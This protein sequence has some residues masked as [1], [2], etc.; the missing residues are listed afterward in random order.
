MEN[1]H[2]IILKLNASLLSLCSEQLFTDY[3]GTTPSEGKN[4]YLTINL[5]TEDEIDQL[6]NEFKDIDATI[7]KSP[8]KVFWGGYVGFIADPEGN[9][10]E[11]AC[12]NSRNQD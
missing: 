6:F 11:I 1:E 12:N 7:I 4:S 2:I 9:L 3:T 8:Q 10:W 5:D